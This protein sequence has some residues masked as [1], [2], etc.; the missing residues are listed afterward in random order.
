[1]KNR[2]I[3]KGMGVD[4]RCRYAIRMLGNELEKGHLIFFLFVAGKKK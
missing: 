3:S 1:M 2:S 4:V